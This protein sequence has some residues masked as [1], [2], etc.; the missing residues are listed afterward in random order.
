MRA[1]DCGRFFVILVCLTCSG[2]SAPAQEKKAPAP[3][4]EPAKTVKIAPPDGVDFHPDLTYRTVGKA[5]LQLDL[6]V[7]K[8]G[9]GPFPAVVIVHGSG[10]WSKGRKF[11]LPLVFELAKKGYVGVTISYRYQPEDVFPAPIHD[12]KS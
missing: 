7:P 10:A 3:P 8:N 1:G 6:A 4:T 5:A 9:P 2:A 11:N 12:A